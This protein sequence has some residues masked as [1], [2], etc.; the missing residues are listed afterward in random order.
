MA[1][2][3]FVQVRKD[4]HFEVL[5]EHPDRIH[6]QALSSQLSSLVGKSHF[7]VSL[8]RNIYVIYLYRQTGGNQYVS[9]RS[10]YML[11]LKL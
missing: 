7:K 2:S 3:Q 5:A 6:P 11:W 4:E 1:L 9:H 10:A 8:R